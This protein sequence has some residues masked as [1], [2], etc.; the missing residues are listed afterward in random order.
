MV[1]VV[2]LLLQPYVENAIWHGLSPKEGSGTVSISI[3]Q[4]DKRLV[5]M[6]DDD[7]VGR[8]AAAVSHSSLPKQPMSSRL[9]QRRLELFRE[10]YRIS[11][12][13]T[14]I[15]KQHADGSGAGTCVMITIPQI[16]EL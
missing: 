4:S 16:Q 11:P 6:I 15:D 13:I 1:E 3:S 14:Y 10:R 7:G 5:C 12:Q 9:N 2:P 8:S